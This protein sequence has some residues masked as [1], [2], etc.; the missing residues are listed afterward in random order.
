[1]CEWQVKL[2]DRIVTHGMREHFRDKG[3]IIKHYINSSV[4]FALYWSGDLLPQWSLQWGY[5]PPV[6]SA[7][8]LCSPS[9]V[10]LPQW[11][12]RRKEL[13]SGGI[14]RAREREPTT[15]AWGRSPQRG[16]RGRAPGQGVRGAK[17][18]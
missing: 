8:G 3:L 13:E 16:S 17:P 14:W 9:G 7:V 10:L 4:Y 1:V 11:Q 2:C 15:G 5:T 6:G 12:G 18:P